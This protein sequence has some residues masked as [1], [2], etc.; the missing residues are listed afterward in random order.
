M[1]E[2]NRKVGTLKNLHKWFA[3]MP[4]P[5]M[6][7]LI[8]A[9][10]VDDP[11]DDVARKDL[12]ELVKRLVPENGA[13]P[14]ADTLREAAARIRA[15][16]PVL[17]TLLDPFAGGG[18]TIVEAQRLGLPAVGSDLNPVAVLIT[19]TLG[20]VLPPLAHAPAVSTGGDSARLLRDPF[21]GLAEDLRHY[22]RSVEEAVKRRLGSAYPLPPRGQPVAWLWART[23]PCTNPGCGLL[24]PLFS[25]PWLSRQPGREATVEAVVNRG[26]VQFVVH[27]GANGPVRST[28]VAGARARFE[29]PACGTRL[30]EQDLRA[31]AMA[32][33]SRLGQ[34]LMTACI[35]TP[36]GRIFLSPEDMVQTGTGIAPP[37]DLDETEIDINRKAFSPPAY[38]L[39]RHID[40]HTRRQLAVLAGFADEVSKVGHR[41]ATDG[42]SKEYGRA[43]ATIMGLCVGKLVQSNSSL[44]RWR[45]DS[46]NGAAKAEPAFG[47]QT[48]PILWDFVETYPFGSSVGSW[49]AQVESVIGVFRVVPTGAPPARVIQTDARRA[50]DLVSPGTGLLVTDPPYFGQINYAGLSDHFYPWLR[51]ALGRVHPDLFATIETPK[52]AELVADPARH[53]GSP[54]EARQYF[55]SGF[56]DVFSSL[57]RAQRPDLPMVVVYAHKQDEVEADG[58]VSTGWESLLE[59]VLAAGLG[60]VGTWPVEATAKT[61]QRGQESNALASY[62]ILV[63][64]PRRLAAESTDRRGFLTA[65]REELPGRL[66]EL[67][68]ASIPPGDLGQAAI[69]PGMAVFSRFARVTEPDGELMPVRTALALIHRVLAEVLYAQEGDL[70]GDS[71]WCVRWF[72]E[73]GF[74]PGDYSRAEQLAWTY[75]TSM[76]G[77]ERAG[78]LRKRA[79]KVVL[80]KPE[81]LPGDY[82]PAS[83]SRRTVWEAVL[84]L[85]SALDGQGVPAAARLMARMTG[86]LDLDAVK[87]LAYLLYSICERRKRQ[88]VA[89]RFNGLGTS[90]PDIVDAVPSA[91]ATQAGS[92]LV[93]DYD[94]G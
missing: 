4:M 73:H 23:V 56:T 21:A 5:A 65:L 44:V 39:T 1:A 41:V 25:S 87:E 2:K 62:V 8:F 13:P 63:C 78:V 31:A 57:L 94:A 77:L 29:C 86:V 37:D 91:A 92:Q 12:I 24:V 16:N 88:D 70:D 26:R 42:G 71:R 72:E 67:Q 36:E 82:D 68:S 60:V 9:S 58:V 53:G 30:S 47:T 59:A 14:D 43:L 17:P 3:P 19:R 32:R 79:G 66:R 40:L 6:R 22:G 90:W 18:S 61:R 69:G 15:S 38:G 75:N 33:P 76:D 34:Q 45:I 46:R 48:M 27:H 85:S 28:K 83:D 55:V 93:M 54:A 49:R 74:E 35:D 84:H 11:G 89:L 7:A 52:S 10:L 51:R 81:E 20:E 50:G 64:R 80:L